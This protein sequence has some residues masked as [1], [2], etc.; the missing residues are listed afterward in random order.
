MTQARA[1]KKS[2]QIKQ[3]PYRVSTLLPAS[4]FASYCAE[5]DL[6]VNPTA[7]ERFHEFGLLVP[8]MKIDL[9]VVEFR[10]IYAEK[11]ERWQ[12]LFIDQADIDKFQYTESNVRMYYH[13]GSAIVHP[14]RDWLGWYEEHDMVGFPADEPFTPW[15]HPFPD[16]TPDPE[17]VDGG[18]V[19]FYDKRQF[20]VL[21]I[22]KKWV[23]HQ[24]LIG[25]TIDAHK[26][27]IL[28]EMIEDYYR[29]LSFYIEAEEY[30]EAWNKTKKEKY[31]K[32]LKKTRN[33]K[34][35]A[36]Q[37]WKSN[38][39]AEQLPKLR[40]KAKEITERHGYVADDIKEWRRFLVEQS[41]F[42]DF[43]A[44]HRRARRYLQWISSDALINSEDCLYMV[45]VLSGFLFFLT[46][47]DRDVYETVQGIRRPEKTA[48]CEICGNLFTPLPHI[49]NAK[50]CSHTCMKKQKLLAS[51]PPL[52]LS[53]KRETLNLYP[54]L[55]VLHMIEIQ[56][57]LDICFH[58]ACFPVF[59]Q[60]VS[61][62]RLYSYR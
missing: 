5:N 60:K 7:L 58:Y 44:E 46:G 12:W 9:G 34:V 25:G 55:A 13:H 27:P 10:R 30:N 26:L 4:Q 1:N 16:F 39:Q 15:M 52:F 24:G 3:S 2:K 51:P 57:S 54:Y 6:R 56:I 22:I 62:R 20:F 53:K 48:R 11:Y 8:A 19:Y 23:G 49:T 18:Y 17:E 14:D 38:F 45:H 29:F 35:E 59:Q 41:I 31:E 43:Q 36:K 47:V 33:R 42:E 61:L 21:K 32:L 37:D 28:K 40:R 50:R